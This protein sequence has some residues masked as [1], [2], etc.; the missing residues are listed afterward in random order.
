MMIV[1]MTLE[2]EFDADMASSLIRSAFREAGFPEDSF[3]RVF[4][5]LLDGL[6]DKCLTVRFREVKPAVGADGRVYLGLAIPHLD[7]ERLVSALRAA[8][9]N[10]ILHGTL[11]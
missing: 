3:E 10:T 1:A 9:L 2:V 7:A 5:Q 6:L 11:Q 4:D 8:D